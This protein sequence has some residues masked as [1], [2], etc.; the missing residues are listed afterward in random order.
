MEIA[1]VFGFSIATLVY[2]SASFSGELNT[3]CFIG[4]RAD[5]LL[6]T[7]VVDNN[8]SQF[9]QRRLTCEVEFDISRFVT[10]TRRSDHM[11]CPGGH[12]NPAVTLACLITRKISALRGVLYVV[13]QVAGAALGCYV[14]ST[15]SLDDMVRSLRAAKGCNMGKHPGQAG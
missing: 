5:Q 13:A 8:C 12:L 9:R 15:V 2:A 14:V 1:L 4:S 7:P 3:A 11:P 10:T 6:A